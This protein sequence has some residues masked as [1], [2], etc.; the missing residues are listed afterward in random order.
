MDCQLHR[1]LDFPSYYV[2]IF[3]IL[4]LPQSQPPLI[5]NKNKTP[6]YLFTACLRYYITIN[7]KVC[8]ARFAGGLFM[9]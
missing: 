8:Q 1:Y 5:K 7:A 3:T 2:L 6:F 9:S 4:H